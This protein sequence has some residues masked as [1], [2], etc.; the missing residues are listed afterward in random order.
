MLKFDWSHSTIRINI[1]MLKIVGLCTKT[2]QTSTFS[3]YKLYSFFTV[4]V[5]MGGHN[6]FQV[7]NIFFVYTDL[8]ALTSNIIV[9]SGSVLVSIKVFFFQ[10]NLKIFNKLVLSLNNEIFQPKN[11]TQRGSAEF[12]VWFYKLVYVSSFSVFFVASFAWLLLP[13]FTNGVQQKQLPFPAW[14]PYDSTVSPFYELS[15]LYQCFAIFYLLTSVVH[16]DTLIFFFMMYII[17]QCDLLC[18]NLRNI[19]HDGHCSANKLI[20]DCVKQH[21]AIVR[22]L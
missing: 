2:A 18:D 14:Y 19:R 17:A 15:Y 7:A 20:I 22:Y 21:R 12:A 10:R 11:E 5:L 1:L 16:I 6:F 3:S 8:E 13:I 9:A 4:V